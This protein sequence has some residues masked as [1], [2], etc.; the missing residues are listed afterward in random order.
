M[1]TLLQ[2]KPYIHDFIEDNL[3]PC[4]KGKVYFIGEKQDRPY[5]PFCL[6]N[7]IA[8]NKD[9]RTSTH[10][11]DIVEILE[12]G[13]TESTKYREK[14]VT[15]Y[16]TC[17]ITVGIYNAW[18][19]NTYD[20][21]D[22]DEAKEYA[23]EQIDLLEGAFEEFPIN[24]LFSVQ[25]IG[26]I[27]PL[28]EVT[29]GGY[30]YRYEFDLTIGYNETRVTNKDLGASIDI[31]IIDTNEP[32]TTIQDGSVYIDEQDAIENDLNKDYYKTQL[33]ITIDNNDNIVV[34]ND[35]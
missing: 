9:K 1:T 23:Y 11:G 15:R 21:V 24:T 27:R 35:I 8:E 13:Q 22:M 20:A 30:I 31:D 2:I 29:E 4:F 5:F 12:S 3:D 33:K 14:I 32:D 7:V 17:V 16:K 18:V 25:N 26:S 28:H 34:E 10:K 19:K 6:L